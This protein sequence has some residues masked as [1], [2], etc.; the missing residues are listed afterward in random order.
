MTI[1]DTSVQQSISSA[2]ISEIKQALGAHRLYGL[3]DTPQKLRLFMQHHIFC[4]WDFM[5]L[6]KS[7]QR[8]LTGCD[9][10]WLPP[11]YPKLARLINEI[12]LDEET[13]NIDGNPISHF[14]LY[15]AAMRE[16]GADLTQIDALLSEVA[17]EAPLA[18]AMNNANVPPC[19]QAFVS[20]TF[21][22]LEE[23]AEVQAAVFFHAR[24]A[25]IPPMFIEMVQNLQHTGLKCDTLVLYLERH[26]MLDGD[27]HGP[28]AQKMIEQ[29]FTH[30]PEL[31]PKAVKAVEQALAARLALWDAL[32]ELME[33]V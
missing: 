4:V 20:A 11:R 19:A 12:V 18:L 7:I 13:D 3:I 2:E 25:I 10:P 24:E 23:T 21:Q 17:C 28:K 9:I 5:S 29:M 16:V 15:S 27:E 26:I 1:V 33:S 14:Q 32:A 8:N 6:L 22:S 30:Q 31:Y